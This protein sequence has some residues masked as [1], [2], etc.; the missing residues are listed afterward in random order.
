MHGLRTSQYFQDEF[1]RREESNES[2]GVVHD[3]R[4][5]AIGF[6]VGRLVVKVVML[7]R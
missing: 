4:G 3:A 7:G 1:E 2:K 6:V 5:D